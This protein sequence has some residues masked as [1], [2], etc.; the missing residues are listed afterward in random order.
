YEGR[1]AYCDKSMDCWGSDADTLDHP[2]PIS[3]N[4]PN[5]PANV[6]PSCKAMKTAKKNNDLAWLFMT[7]AITQDTYLTILRSIINHR[8]GEELKQHIKTITG[9]QDD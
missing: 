1:C 7:G 6:L 9:L 4:T 3:E 5:V 8:G 2:F